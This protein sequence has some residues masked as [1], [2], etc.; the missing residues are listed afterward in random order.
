VSLPGDPVPP[1][2]RETALLVF[3]E[4]PAPARAT[5]IRAQPSK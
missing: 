1:E 4:H 2:S 5:E 3:F